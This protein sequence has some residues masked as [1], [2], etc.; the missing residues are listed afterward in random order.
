M[1]K[2]LI[3]SMVGLLVIYSSP[4]ATYD[5]LLRNNHRLALYAEFTL[6]YRIIAPLLLKCN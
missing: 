4:T 6:E 1:L 2:P 3:H 5:G